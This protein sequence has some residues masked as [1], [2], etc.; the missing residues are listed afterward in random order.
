MEDLYIR[1][2]TCCNPL[3]GEEVVGYV[4]RG[5]GIAIHREGCPNIQEALT[6]EPDRIQPVDWAHDGQEKFATP[7]RIETMDRVGVMADVSSAFSERKI[8]IEQANIRTRADKSAVWDLVVDVAD[9]EELEHVIRVVRAI[10]DVL[11][12]S[13]PG[14]AAPAARP[15]ARTRTRRTARP[16]APAGKRAR[17]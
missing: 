2:S 17:D 10:P 15:V 1:R 8:N 9:V 5:K 7:L 13:R 6:N 4:T 14:P 11:D 12:V 3:P 16:A